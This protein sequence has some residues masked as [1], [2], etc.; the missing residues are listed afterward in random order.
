MEVGQRIIIVGNTG[1]GKSTLAGELSHLFDIPHI[2]LDA[3]QWN[4]NWIP[5]PDSEF[6]ER[7]KAAI[8]AAG[9]QWVVDGNYGIAREIIWSQGDTLIWLDYP[10]YI[11]YWRLFRRTLQRTIGKV[12]LWNGNRERFREQFL[13]RESLFLWAWQS[14]HRRNLT[15]SEII[16]Q[17]QFP[18]LQIL[19]FKYP[20]ETEN[21]LRQL[22]VVYSAPEEFQ[23]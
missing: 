9:Q 13:S 22:Q 14:H 18:N 15:Y 16:S 8:S 11:I 12:E 1:S 2:E 4:A 3:L 20:R 17:N 10:L 5:T 6:R 7:V 21:W 23:P 19:H